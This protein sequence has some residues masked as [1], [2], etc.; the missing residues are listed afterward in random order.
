MGRSAALI[1]SIRTGVD[2]MDLIWLLLV[3]FPSSCV[4]TSYRICHSCSHGD[5][6][7]EVTIRKGGLPQMSPSPLQNSST[8]NSLKSIF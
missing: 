8:W 7:K 1:R 5:G 6:K 4:S 2:G 3:S